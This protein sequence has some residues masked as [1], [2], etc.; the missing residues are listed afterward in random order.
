MQDYWLSFVTSLTPNDG[1]GA[2]RKC[3]L[4]T[5]HKSTLMQIRYFLFQR[6]YLGAVHT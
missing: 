1:R 2:R 3:L 4:F 5:M 6:A